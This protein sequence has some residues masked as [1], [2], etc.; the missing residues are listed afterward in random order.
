M[1]EHSD[2]DCTDTIYRFGPFELS[3]ANHALYRNGTLV[4]IQ[5]QPFQMLLLLIKQQGR[6]VSKAELRDSLWGTE[7]F[8]EVDQ[9][10]YVIAGKLRDLLGDNAVTPR[11]IK[12]ISG[13]GYQFI[14]PI[15]QVLPP[16]LPAPLDSPQAN[17][18]YTEEGD[19]ERASLLAEKKSH[20]I[21]MQPELPH[22]SLPLSLPP[23]AAARATKRISLSLAAGF[24]L[25]CVAGAWL[26]FYARRPIYAPPQ[27]IMVG[28][29]SD[30]SQPSHFNQMLA[31]LV[32]LKLQ[33]SPYLTLI[34]DQQIAR[35]KRDPAINGREGELQVCS[36]L[37]GQLLLLSELRPNASGYRILLTASRCSDGKILTTQQADADS[38]ASLLTA[39]DT[40]TEKMRKRLGEPASSLRRF[41]MPLVESTTISLAALKEFTEGEQKLKAGNSLAAISNFKTAVDLD[42]HFA[43]GYAKL[44]TIYLN[45]QEPVSA[46]KY[47]RKAFELRDT[48]TDKE[49]LYIAAHYYTDVTGELQHAI[50]T[51]DLWTTLYPQDW[52]PLNNLA[53]L[54]DLLGRPEKALVYAR[55]AAQINPNAVLS[56]STLAQAYLERNDSQQLNALCSDPAHGHNNLITFHNICFLGSFAQHDDSAMQRQLTWAK[57][58]PQESLLLDTAASADLGSGKIREAHQIFS[59]ARSNALANK[60]PEI[61]TVMDLD[62]AIGDAE[63]GSAGLAANS[64]QKALKTIPHDIEAQAYASIILAI[65]RRDD[66]ALKAAEST[67]RQ[68]EMNDAISR[69]GLPTVKAILALHHHHPAEAVAY[70]EPS[71]SFLL[72]APMKFAPAYYLG[73]AYLQNHQLPQAAETFQQILQNRGIAADSIYLGLAALSLGQTLAL[74]GD[75]RGAAKAY[76]LA[77]ETW[78]GADA[79]FP[80]LRQ[81]EVSRSSLSHTNIV[82]ISH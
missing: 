35:I 57:G 17:A 44:G 82:N 4:R 23:T 68:A 6:V 15:T 47:I 11:F 25:C 75:S 30:A 78:R 32:Q 16:P 20:A 21:A 74:E 8:V 37:G 43:L 29:P 40:V 2:T 56:T 18:E 61:A 48:T 12:T 1:E 13:R 51:Y 50:E 67:Y 3:A 36:S 59:T 33:Q 66:L 58:N 55:A 5:D 64:V 27:T 38:E 71:K 31:F 45:A 77:A 14:G 34:S 52:G 69:L 26:Y 39:I 65:A 73:V 79:G 63:F 10:L 60:L 46:A 72:F 28:S 76:D 19:A 53:N 41:N 62:E 42:P 49:R 54:Y 9:N 7:T 81:L 22:T 24:L 70:L 80:S